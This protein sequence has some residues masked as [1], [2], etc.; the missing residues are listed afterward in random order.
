MRRALADKLQ[1]ADLPWAPSAEAVQQRAAG[2]AEPATGMRRLTGNSKLRNH[3]AYALAV[4]VLVALWGGYAQGWKWTGFQANG[5]LWD[6]L[7]LLL[8]PVVIGTIPLWIQRTGLHQPEQARHPRGRYR[9]LDRVRDRRLPGSA[10]L[11]R[12]PWPDAVGLV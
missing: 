6:W 9:G 1:D 10:Q 3:A 5:Q 2:A 7:N 12:L 8:L 4:A 11:D